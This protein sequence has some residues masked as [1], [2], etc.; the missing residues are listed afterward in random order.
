M[1]QLAVPGTLESPSLVRRCSMAL[2]D[3]QLVSIGEEVVYTWIQGT[4][5]NVLTSVDKSASRRIMQK[6]NKGILKCKIFKCLSISDQSP[7]FS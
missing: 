7:I 2:E 3:E 5:D 6:I 1:N 4:M